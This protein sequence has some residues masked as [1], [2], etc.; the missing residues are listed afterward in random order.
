VREKILP[1]SS[2]LAWGKIEEM[3]Q[4]KPYSDVFLQSSPVMRG[5]SGALGQ[6]D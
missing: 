6:Y 4:R 3:T 1:L 5:S 2:L